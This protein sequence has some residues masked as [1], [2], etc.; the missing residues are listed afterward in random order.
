MK[1]IT[2]AAIAIGWFAIAP[3]ATA[4]ARHSGP[5]GY[6]Y[7]GP[8]FRGSPMYAPNRAPPTNY[9]N[10]GRRVIPPPGTSRRK[11]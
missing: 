1:R 5:Y 3:D 9:Y 10:R 7:R 8:S 6:Y 11:G 4:H 2:G